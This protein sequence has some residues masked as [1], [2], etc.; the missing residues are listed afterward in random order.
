MINTNAMPDRARFSI[1]HLEFSRN[2]HFAENS[3]FEYVWGWFLG[4]ADHFIQILRSSLSSVISTCTFKNISHWRL[5][6]LTIVQQITEA[7]RYLARAS[8]ERKKQD[9]KTY[10]L[11]MRFYCWFITL[12]LYL[13]LFTQRIV[14]VKFILLMYTCEIV[15]CTTVSP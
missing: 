2:N 10:G 15:E 11:W 6:P 8:T 7:Y 12:E 14:F 3:K 9:E 1:F 4:S 13:S 5:L